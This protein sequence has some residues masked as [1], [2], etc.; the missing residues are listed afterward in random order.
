MVLEWD[1][2]TK[3]KTTGYNALVKHVLGVPPLVG[4]GGTGFVWLP[5]GVAKLL[6]ASQDSVHIVT[7]RPYLLNGVEYLKLMHFRYSTP[8]FKKYLN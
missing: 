8:F 7:T 1:T 4:N 6:L 2:I 3:P 5:R